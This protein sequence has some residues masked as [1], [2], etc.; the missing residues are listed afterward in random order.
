MIHE[1]F[2]NCLSVYQAIE[3]AS[4]CFT[5]L[6]PLAVEFF[7]ERKVKSRSGRVAARGYQQLASTLMAGP[8][9]IYDEKPNNYPTMPVVREQGHGKVCCSVSHVYKTTP[10]TGG[11]QCTRRQGAL[12]LLLGYTTA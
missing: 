10:N 4:A 3:Q 7:Y 6:R 2:E 11:I 8:W 1:I 5:G 9:R 12:K